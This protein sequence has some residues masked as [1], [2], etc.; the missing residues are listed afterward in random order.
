[1][2]GGTYKGTNR[3]VFNFNYGTLKIYYE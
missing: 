2:V 1:M 3:I